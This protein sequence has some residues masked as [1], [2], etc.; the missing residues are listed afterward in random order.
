MIEILQLSIASCVFSSV[1][2]SNGFIQLYTELENDCFH[3]NKKRQKQ[4]HCDLKNFH[5]GNK[6]YILDGA[7]SDIGC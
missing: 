7:E 2:T 6:K 5:Q 3:K 1:E 4:H